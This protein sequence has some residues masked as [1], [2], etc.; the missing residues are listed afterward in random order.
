[1]IILNEDTASAVALPAGACDCHMHVFGDPTRYPGAPDRTYQP[2]EMP[3]DKYLPIAQRLGLERFVI[4]QP[5]AYGA[6]NSCT[7]DAH[8]ANPDSARAVIV[9]GEDTS[10]EE[11]QALDAAGVRGIRLNLMTPR[12]AD[13]ETAF[14][15]LEAA[16]RRIGRLGWHIQIYAD[17]DVVAA[18]A[19]VLG[20]VGV[21]V[22]FDHMGGVKKA[23]AIDD[24]R[25]AAL[26]EALSS[27]HCWVK[28]SGADIVSWENED[29][30]AASPFAQ[31]LLAAATDRLVW[32]S[33]WPHLVHHSSGQGDAAPLAG[34]RP[35]N[36]AALL[37]HLRQWAGAEA[38]LKRVMVDNPASL[39]RF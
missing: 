27:G 5:S 16:S 4:V 12:V 15:K 23:V 2:T 10:F 22:V 29:F 8:K 34:Y 3:L 11:L 25:F 7:L 38:T 28:L 9:I 31:A 21:P 26:L 36:E 18:I 37:R 14:A 6:D 20:R 32:G 33:D 13:N 24:P 1:M 35:V 39:Y 30:S 17:L 19:P